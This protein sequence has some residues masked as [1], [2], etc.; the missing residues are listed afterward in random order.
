MREDL[1]KKLV[2]TYP[3][4][5]K[6][7]YADMKTTCMCWGFTCGDGWYPLIDMLCAMLYNDY[8]Q[9]KQT[10]EYTVSA[11]GKKKYDGTLYSQE[12]VDEAKAKMDEEEK[13]VPVAS[14]VKEKF[15]S[16]RFYTG[17]A[18]EKHHEYIWFAEAMSSRI[19]EKCGATAGTRTWT[20]GWMSTLCEEHAIEHY[21]QEAVDRMKKGVDEQF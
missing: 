9:A 21:G 13:L 20:D 12:D 3:L 19:C 6:N 17:P 11:L 2:E 1:D 7:R 4:I 16:L 8:D 15:G 14:Q 10:Y 18:K 5:F